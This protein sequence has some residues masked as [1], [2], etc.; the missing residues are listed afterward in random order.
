LLNLAP[1]ATPVQFQN[2]DIDTP[3]RSLRT[4]VNGVQPNTNTTRV[5]GA[6]SINVWLPHHSGYIQPAETIDTVAIST[7]SF[8]A[9]TGFA[10]GAA[11]TVVA[12][13]GTNESHG[14]AFWSMGGVWLV[15]RCQVAF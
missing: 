12:K 5:H 7:N 6:V 15:L 3:G 4:W 13:S 10:G 2:A 14:S 11:Q 1:G 9:D 8:E